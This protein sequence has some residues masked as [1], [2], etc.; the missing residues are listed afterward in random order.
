MSNETGG[1]S[2]KRKAGIGRSGTTGKART[3]KS[4]EKR[5][6]TSNID[7]T[8]ADKANPKPK[9]GQSDTVR[10]AVQRA[11]KNAFLNRGVASSTWPSPSFRLVAQVLALDTDV[12]AG[13]RRTWAASK[14]AHLLAG[15]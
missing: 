6:T 7:H 13:S 8:P 2:S 3:A 12:A 9:V 5:V 4:R 14:C 10:V 15:C 1:E 11:A